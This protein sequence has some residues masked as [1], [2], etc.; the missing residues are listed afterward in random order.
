MNSPWPAT[1]DDH[2]RSTDANADSRL[3][4]RF[5]PMVPRGP[6]RPRPEWIVL[7]VALVLAG[8]I[9]TVVCVAGFAVNVI[10]GGPLH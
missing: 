3:G 4:F 6:R 2:D 1:P 7:T 9:L 10:T 8:L 5:A